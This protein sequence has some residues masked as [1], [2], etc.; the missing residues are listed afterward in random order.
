MSYLPYVW[1]RNRK[2]AEG[3]M[4]TRTVFDEHEYSGD[5]TP[6]ELGTWLLQFDN[7][8]LLNYGS[9]DEPLHVYRSKQVPYTEEEIQAA[10]EYIAN[11][12]KPEQKSVQLHVPRIDLG[13]ELA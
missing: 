6:G 9:E 13:K 10:K 12:P 1:E 3:K 11:N 7:S 2:I 5:P 4:K 8:W